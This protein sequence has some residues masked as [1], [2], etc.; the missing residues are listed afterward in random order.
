MGSSA[1][2]V[3]EDAELEE[4]LGRVLDRLEPHAAELWRLVD[5]GHWANWFCYVGSHATEHA[6][7]IGR[8]LMGRMLQLPG[9]LW[10]DVHGD[11]PDE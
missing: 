2:G 9:D 8:S 6:V 3:A 5:D 11:D 1:S 10:L 4:A 7:E